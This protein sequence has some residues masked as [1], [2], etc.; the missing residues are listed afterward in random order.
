MSPPIARPFPRFMSDTVQ[1]PKPYGD[2]ADRLRDAFADACAPLAEE[3]GAALDPETLLFFPERTWGGRTYQP[4]VGFAAEEDGGL[5]EYFGYIRFERGKD[6]EP[7]E[8][9]A[10]ADFADV[11]AEDNPDWE[12]DLNDAVVG[13]WKADGGRGGEVTL[14]WGRPLVRGAI[15]ASAE[16]ESDVLDQAAINDGRFSLL[17]VDAVH[18]FGDE[19]YLEIKLWDRRLNQVAAESLYDDDV[20]GED[21]EEEGQSTPS[22]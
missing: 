18:G 19:L 3:A 4:V 1:E 6:G 15:A 20:E 7:G 12:I 10:D 5:P 22:G 14:I 2:W 11:T 13:E 9:V 8:L 21:E 17:A 16:L